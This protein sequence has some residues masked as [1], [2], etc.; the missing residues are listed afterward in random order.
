MKRVLW[1]VLPERGHFHPMLGPAAAAEAAGLEVAFYSPRDVRGPLALAGF[2]RVFG[3]GPGELPGA[4]NRGADFAAMLRDPAQLR[5]WIELML[6]EGARADIS[7]L[8]KV[9]REY[10]PDVIAMDSM[11]YSGAIVAQTEGLPWLSVSTSL[12][13]VVPGDFDTEL[14][15]TTTALEPRRQALFQDAGL[16]ARF[17]ISDVLSPH[18]TVAF[19]TEALAGAAPEGVSLV[20][21]SAPLRPRGEAPVDLSFAAGRPLVYMSLGTQ[22]FHQPAWFARMFEA[23]RGRPY[24]LLASMGAEGELPPGGTL[25]ENVR[26][27][28]HAPQ[29]DVLAR[30]SLFVT[31]GGAN[32]VMEGL[33]AGVPL[34]VTPICN[35]Q[36]HNLQLLERAGAGRRVDLEALSPAAL[37]ELI[38]DVLRPRHPL[39]LAARD[40]QHSYRARSGA[41]AVA[42]RLVE[43]AG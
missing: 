5:A 14:I 29:L 12:N 32:S 34:L 21:P 31:H 26:C 6:V 1:V 19:T 40:L 7:P 22:A 41:D 3:A 36:F 20:G 18:G 39:R 33:H 10:R 17:R 23:A 27:V 38:E 16:T 42:R 15:R 8:R 30:A 37:G 13:P 43:L 9:V 25:P 2:S 28:A 4:S 24:A 35:D 11:A